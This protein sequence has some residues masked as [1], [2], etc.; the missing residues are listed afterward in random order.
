MQTSPS[1]I[2]E[3][4]ATIAALALIFFLIIRR[5][6]R[7][8]AKLGYFSSDEPPVRLVEL[9]R[10][11][12]GYTPVVFLERSRSALP[13]RMMVLDTAGDEAPL[14]CVTARTDKDPGGR[15]VFLKAYGNKKLLKLADRIGGGLQDGEYS[16]RGLKPMKEFNETHLGTHGVKAYSDYSPDT[17]SEDFKRL[18]AP[19]LSF[20][21]D[22]IGAAC[23]EGYVMA[24]CGS[25]KHAHEVCESMAA[26]VQSG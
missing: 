18:L 22:A 26:A 25:P 9:V 10:A 4:L 15:L 14:Y 16:G 17:A 12:T 5:R 13:M 6:E 7:R 24:W 21:A 19:F 1:G 8:I 3:A 2:I 23:A 11:V 20:S